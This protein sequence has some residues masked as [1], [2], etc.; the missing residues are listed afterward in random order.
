MIKLLAQT[1]FKITGKSEAIDAKLAQKAK[2][3]ILELV[4]GGIDLT[5]IDIN[6]FSSS[7]PYRVYVGNRYSKNGMRVYS[8]FSKHDVES[9][10]K[11]FSNKFP[12]MWATGRFKKA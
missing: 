1:Y 4:A 6:D 11:W 9:C 3:F 12:T 7:Y 10:I 5:D 2:I 8:R